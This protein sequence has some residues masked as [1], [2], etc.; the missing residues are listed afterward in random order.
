MNDIIDKKSNHM[1]IETYSGMMNVKYSLQTKTSSE[2]YKRSDPL[3]NPVDKN[4]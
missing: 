1:G 3:H 4:M 2:L